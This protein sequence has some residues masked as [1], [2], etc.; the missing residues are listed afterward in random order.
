MKETDRIVYH[1]TSLSGLLGITESESIWATNILYL[2]DASELH[3][4]KELLK[5]ELAIFRGKN[6]EFVRA[7]TLDKSL[8]H[9]FLETVENNIN[10]LL[11]SQS[12][13]FFVC[14]FSEEGDLL[15]QWRGYSKSSTGFSLGFSLNRLK[16]IVEK[17]RFSIRKVIYDRDEQVAEIQRLLAD[18]AAKFT[19]DIVNAVD[20]G[21]AWDEKSKLLLADFFL[22][23]IRLAP[24]LKHQKFA[25]EKEW[26]IMAVLQADH[27][28]SAMKFRAAGSMVVPY[29]EVPLPLE[30]ESLVINEIIVGPTTEGALSAASIEMLLKSRKVVCSAVK[31]STIPYRTP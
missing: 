2:N 22:E 5:E 6:Q 21:R 23:F 24:M 20:K 19:S 11:P 27:I 12:I 3:Y 4:A 30:G 1:Y 28:S 10:T 29:I 14:S 31:C 7:D 9:F 25:E 16:A 17:A 8:G 18:L 26:R 13:G 15:S